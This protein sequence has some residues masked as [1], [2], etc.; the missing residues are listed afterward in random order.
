MVPEPEGIATVHEEQALALRPQGLLQGLAEPPR[1]VQ[2]LISG[3]LFWPPKGRKE[4]LEED[5][6]RG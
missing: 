1:A 5:M 3:H 2:V 4:R 6:R